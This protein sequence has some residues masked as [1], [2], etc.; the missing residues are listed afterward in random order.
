MFNWL[1]LL[2]RGKKVTD[3]IFNRRGKNEYDHANFKPK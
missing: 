1:Q 2:V 3:W